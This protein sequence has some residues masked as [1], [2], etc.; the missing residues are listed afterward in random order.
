LYA[1]QRR[2]PEDDE[3]LLDPELL[4]EPPDEEPLAPGED[5]PF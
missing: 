4:P 5:G 2:L 1:D 3:L